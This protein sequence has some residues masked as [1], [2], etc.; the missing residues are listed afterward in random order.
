M[1]TYTTPPDMAELERD[2]WRR[3]DYATASLA[4]QLMDAEEQVAELENEGFDDAADAIQR[5]REAEGR[6]EKAEEDRDKIRAD[7]RDAIENM[8]RLLDSVKRL[9][10]RADITAAVNA[11]AKAAGEP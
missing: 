3:G 8:D 6:A 9:P 5:C 7:V 2:A 10:R 11:I 1:A 4:G